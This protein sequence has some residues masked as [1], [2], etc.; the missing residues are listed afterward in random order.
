MGGARGR[1]DSE[2]GGAG[3]GRRRRR[4]R[5]GGV[6]SYS[7][8]TIEGPRAPA[9]KLTAR[10]SSLTRVRAAPL[11]PGVHFISRYSKTR[12]CTCLACR[13]GM[14]QLHFSR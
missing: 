7:A 11:S 6:Y 10:H 14:G 8:D 12:S 2:R 13:L 3:G 4:R 9:V 5:G 1:D